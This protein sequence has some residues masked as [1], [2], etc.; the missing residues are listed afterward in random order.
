MNGT[1][2]KQYA[3]ATAQTW[4]LWGDRQ[5]SLHVRVLEG[6]RAHPGNHLEY[7]VVASCTDIVSGKSQIDFSLPVTLQMLVHPTSFPWPSENMVRLC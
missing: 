5:R 7:E 6:D 1:G 3:P 2:A 4:L